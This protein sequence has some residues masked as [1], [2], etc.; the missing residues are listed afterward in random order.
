MRDE[1][2][3]RYTETAPPRTKKARD[4]APGDRVPTASDPKIAAYT[5]DRAPVLDVYNT[6]RVLVAVTWTDGGQDVRTIDADFDV[7]VLE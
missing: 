4:L 1:L 7:P 2:R 5:V 3:A 6:R